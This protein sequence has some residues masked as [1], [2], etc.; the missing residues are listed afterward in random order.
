MRTWRSLWMTS[1]RQ[2]VEPPVV[3]E[4][5]V[6]VQRPDYHL[7]V[8][9]QVIKAGKAHP[10]PGGFDCSNVVKLVEDA[11]KGM[12]FGDDSEII[13][14]HATK[15]WVLDRDDAGTLVTLTTAGAARYAEEA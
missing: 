2:R 14:V 10:Y 15:R 1:G 9:R 4:V 3:L 6:R 12:A 13:A 11:L 8:Q 7:G 5:Y